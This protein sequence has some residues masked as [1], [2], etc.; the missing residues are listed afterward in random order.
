MLINDNKLLH[1]DII[2]KCE[3]VGHYV[4]GS[5]GMVTQIKEIIAK[6]AFSTRLKLITNYKNKVHDFNN[7]PH[8]NLIKS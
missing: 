2:G 7:E 3:K 6:T 1:N 4:N 8:S 5:G